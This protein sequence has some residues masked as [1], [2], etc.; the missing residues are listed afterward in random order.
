MEDLKELL[1]L[2]KKRKSCLSKQFTSSKESTITKRKTKKSI[3]VENIVQNILRD[4]MNYYEQENTENENINN[5]QKN[6]HLIEDGNRI[7]KTNR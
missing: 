7:K 1:E 3:L 2:L 4:N 6:K 5:S